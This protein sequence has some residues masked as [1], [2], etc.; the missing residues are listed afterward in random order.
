M[1]SAVM[2]VCK[3]L[4]MMKAPG[5]EIFISRAV[6][7]AFPK[8]YF[9]LLRTLGGGVAGLIFGR[10]P[11]ILIPLLCSLCRFAAGCPGFLCH[12]VLL[13]FLVPIVVFIFQFGCGVL[14]F[15]FSRI[16][17]RLLA[18]FVCYLLGLLMATHC[19]SSPECMCELLPATGIVEYVSSEPN[20]DI[21]HFWCMVKCAMGM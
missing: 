14:G 20:F 11:R 15:V 7:E 5:A 1:I 16:I 9:Y 17:L 21:C 2:A 4:V 3:P 8:L 19:S 18:L 6:F 12:N 10:L 13:G